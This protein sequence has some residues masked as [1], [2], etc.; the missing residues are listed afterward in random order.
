MRSTISQE[1]LNELV[2]LSIEQNLLE[3]I[4]IDI[5]AMCK[6]IW[7]WSFLDHIFSLFCSLGRLVKDPRNQGQPWEL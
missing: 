6:G 3:N 5:H 1:R 4:E 2:I 7:R